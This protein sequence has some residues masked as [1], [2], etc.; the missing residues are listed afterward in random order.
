MNIALLQT[1]AGAASN[2]LK[3]LANESRLLIMCQL[4]NGEKPVHE[5]EELVGMSQSALSQ[6]LA[7]LRR[8][9][10][11]T[12]RREAQFVHYS[13]A[14]DEARAVIAALYDIFCA[15]QKKRK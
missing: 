9:R 12:T 4:V 5:L 7:I 11:V 15:P 14:S 3:V 6:H 8:E 13:L 2:L 10:L 1:R